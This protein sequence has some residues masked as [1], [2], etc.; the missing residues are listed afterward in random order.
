M[1]TLGSDLEA[2]ENAVRLFFQTIKRP[3]YWARVTTYSGV[4]IDRPS[5]VILQSLVANKTARCRVQDLAIQLGIEA[6]SVT[7]KTKELEQAGLVRRITD[8]HDRRAIDLQVTANGRTVAKHLWKAQ[9]AIMSHALGQWQP[10]ERQQFVKLFQ[11]FSHDLAAASL[12]TQFT[13][14]VLSDV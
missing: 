10:T 6:P 12:A 13:D 14:N 2:L 11:K 1:S 7:R 5:A 9:R 8:S 4:N 3:R